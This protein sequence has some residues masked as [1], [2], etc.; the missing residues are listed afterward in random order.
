MR[1]L[2]ESGPHDSC[3]D[4]PSTVY[5][6][7]APMMAYRP[8]TGSKPATTAMAMTCGIMYAATVTPATTSPRSQ[9]RSYLR[10]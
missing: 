8:T 4:D 6:T 3:G 7:S 2:V 5:T 9:R 1:A 10:R